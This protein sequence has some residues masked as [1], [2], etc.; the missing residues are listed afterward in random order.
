MEE[1]KLDLAIKIGCGRYRQEANLM[2]KAGEEI[3]RF[4]NNVLIVAG[5]RAFDAV[6]D[7][8]LVSL[9]KE[10]IRYE[11]VIHTGACC[12][13]AAKE[14]SDLMIEK[15]LDEVV[16]VGGGKIM[17]L[18]KAIAEYGH[19]GTI[20][21]PTS[22]S[23]CAPYTCMSVMYTKDGGKK[24]C[25]RYEHEL[26]A[27]LIDN[28]VIEACPFRYNAAGILDAM[29]KKIEI[30]HG[31]KEMLLKNNEIKRFAAYKMAEYS[32]EMLK[33][34][35]RAAFIEH[36]KK[37]INDVTY[38]AVA[39]TGAIANMT[40][41]FG[42][43]AIAHSFYDCVRT[44]FT[45]EAIDYLHGEIVAVGM[46]P[47]LYFNEDYK[48]INNLIEYMKSFNMPTTLK[49]IGI[50]PSKENVDKI[51]QYLLDSPYIEDREDNVT[52]LDEALKT[53]LN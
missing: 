12:Y 24:D 5:K 10:E 38:I 49:E 42:Q 43:S 40:Q 29:A 46:I 25:W 21:I 28:D 19:F 53:I 45:K 16:G 44:L 26:D 6:K 4:S 48:E 27:L 13:E 22:A 18:S 41:S 51:K 34:N 14:Y 3:K 11:I 1:I 35:G 32:Y 15:G 33:E 50:E 17:D 2:E 20:N 36:D 37:A 8:L 23:T 7:K 39:Y 30:Q 52:K 9:D 47:Q 31:Q